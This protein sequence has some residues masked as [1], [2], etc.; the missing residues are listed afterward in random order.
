MNFALIVHPWTYDRKFV[1]VII[2]VL[3]GAGAENT[4]NSKRVD[5]GL[6]KKM[7]NPK[8]QTGDLKEEI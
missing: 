8:F 7:Q 6:M 5:R 1:Y 2:D 4:Q 3:C